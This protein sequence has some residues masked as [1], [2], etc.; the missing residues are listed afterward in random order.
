[1][2]RCRVKVCGITRAGD[3]QEAVNAGADAVGFVFAPS[4]RK[5]TPE[6]ASRMARMLPPLVSAVGVFVDEAAETVE[7]VVKD[8]GLAAAQLHG[9]ETADYCEHLRARNIRVIKAVRMRDRG[10]LD[11]LEDD[12]GVDAF[13]LDSFAEDVRG[14]S[15]ATFDWQL[16]AG[17]VG[18][19]R[20]VIVAGGL[21]P[22]NVGE[23]VRK[24]R[25]FGV[26]VS[27]GVEA[28]PGK[29]DADMVR[30]FLRAVRAAEAEVEGRDG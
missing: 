27:S 28:A 8:C 24:L 10:S 30:G 26:D 19:R 21:T 2:Y 29:K 12:G 13:L 7:R 14:G 18:C 23:V 11:A 6:E 5:V 17:A 4:P 25:P 15:G 1:M 20:P 22:S 3:L 16:A 9:D